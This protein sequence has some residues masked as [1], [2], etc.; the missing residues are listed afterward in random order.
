M[1]LFPFFGDW[2]LV[3]EDEVDFVVGAFIGTWVR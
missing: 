3:T 2:I 1:F